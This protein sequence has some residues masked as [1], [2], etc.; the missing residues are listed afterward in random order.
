MD[1]PRVDDSL[2]DA[3]ATRLSRHRAKELL[4]IAVADEEAQLGEAVVDGQLP[5]PARDQGL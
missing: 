1:R 2:D 5:R 4:A 3:A